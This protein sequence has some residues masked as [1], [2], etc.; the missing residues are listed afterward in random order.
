MSELDKGYRIPLINEL[1]D[2]L[3]YEVYSPGYYDTDIEDI[4]GWY[5]YTI[6]SDW[7]DIEDIRKE[8]SEGNI[9]VKI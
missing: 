1:I 8:L 4:A 9:R 7:R 5:P 6:D 2:G 3:A